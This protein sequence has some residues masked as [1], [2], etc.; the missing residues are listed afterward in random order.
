MGGIGRVVFIAVKSFLQTVGIGIAIKSFVTPAIGTVLYY[1][2]GFDALT[3]GIVTAALI[4]EHYGSW[5]MVGTLAAA[6]LVPSW[7][8]KRIL[9]RYPR[10]TKWPRACGHS[11]RRLLR[12]RKP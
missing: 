6:L 1:T 2:T 7:I 9:H 5:S 10:L 12:I 11:A 3:W 8:A 4:K